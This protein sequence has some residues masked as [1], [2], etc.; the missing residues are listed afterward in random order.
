MAVSSPS[1]AGSH[2]SDS[3]IAGRVSFVLQ[4]AAT[5]WSV[6]ISRL[7]NVARLFVTLTPPRPANTSV[8][9][10]TVHQLREVD[11]GIYR[12]LDIYCY[13]L[14][15]RCTYQGVDIVQ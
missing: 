4:R 6:R 14:L 1:V 5:L 9:V 10:L 13:T 8:S 11:Q 15:Y 3:S 7:D 2:W 12:Y